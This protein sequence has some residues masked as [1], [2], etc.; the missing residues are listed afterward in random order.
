MQGVTEGESLVRSGVR[1]R[2]DL[3]YASRTDAD[4]TTWVVKDPVTL[5]YFH[6]GPAEVFIMR[7]I[8]GRHSL[9]AIQAEYEAQFAPRRISQGEIASFCHSLYQRGLLVA[10][11]DNQ[12][13]GLLRRRQKQ[14]LLRWASMPL[15]ILAIRL[16]GV[17]PERFLTATKGLV[18]WL[19]HRVTV[20]LVLLMALGTLVLGLL[21]AETLLARLPSE[22]EF[23][24]G[25]NLV[26]LVLTFMLVKVLHELGHA[27]ACKHFG[28]ECHQIGVLLMVFAPAMYCDVSDAWLLRRRGQRI[29]VSAA[30]MYVEVILAT[31]CALLWY[32]AQQGPV[33]DWLLNVVLVCGVSTLLV[34]ANPLLRYDGYYILSDLLNLPNLS[35]RA[36]DALWSP[37]RR[38][39]FQGDPTWQPDEPRALTLR[40]YAV[41]AL[42][43]R[44]LVFGLILW[45]LYKAARAND[46][47]PL[48]HAT[49]VLFVAGLLLRPTMRL[50]QWLKRPRRRGESMNRKR[51]L[52]AAS[53]VGLMV[54]AVGMIPIPSRVHVPVIA[55]LHHDQRVYVQVEGR[56]QET[57]VPGTPVRAGDVIAQLQNDQ[58]QA[59]LL[60]IQGELK[61]QR[62]HLEGLRLR[63]NNN[64]EAAAQIPTAESALRDLEQQQAV[65]TR[66][67][68]QLTIRAPADG[69]VISAPQKVEPERS[70]LFLPTWSGDP[71]EQANRGCLL[72]RGTLLCLVGRQTSLQVR[73]FVPQ[74]QIA[75]VQ[76]GHH[77]ALLLDG[78]GMQALTGQIREVSTDQKPHVPRNLAAHEALGVVRQADGTAELAR[79]AFSATVDLQPL[80]EV[81]I[82]P[83]TCGRGIVRGHSQTVWQVVARWV[84]LNFRFFA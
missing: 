76:P 32:F 68:Q 62:Q 21:G 31:C 7:L 49:V 80:P 46:V 8:D 22:S 30:G 12:A 4:E 78:A 47:L 44:C 1:V 11:A 50:V 37:L 81:A 43:Y 61:L 79:G 35:S 20:T 34:N 39:F 70:G 72:A 36:S 60:S 54:A 28:G 17:D 58:L 5:R 75:L 38:W 15:Q 26:I 55:E 59:E 73:I 84:Q 66:Q 33:R 9:S 67:I 18:E 24:R 74:D 2:P 71:L 51:V 82:L 40:V 64:P 52:L 69:V 63:S 14:Q 83:G 3:V 10:A 53:L 19:F 6:F 25:E 23:F 45:F 48:W 56:A 42:L 65:L 27:Y 13:A 16:P 77:V 29:F 41:C 57:V